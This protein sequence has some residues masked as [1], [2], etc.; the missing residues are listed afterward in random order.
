MKAGV[1][2]AL[3]A[4]TDEE[5]PDSGIFRLALL[6]VV[7]ELGGLGGGIHLRG[8]TTALRLVCSAG[9]P[10][11]LTRSWDVVSQ[12]EALAPAQAVLHGRDA[13]V[14]ASLSAPS[15]PPTEP[16]PGAGSASVPFFSGERAVGAITVLCEDEPTGEQW[17]FLRA[18]ASWTE[19]RT[20]KAAPTPSPPQEPLTGSG[21]RQAL[22]DV[23]IRAWEWDIHT[24]AL[25]WDAHATDVHDAIAQGYA[26]RIESWMKAVHP[27]DL[28]SA[29]AAAERMVREGVPYEAEYRQRRPD[30]SYGW[31]QA[32]GWVVRDDRGEP[33]RA[34]GVAW[35]TSESST[36]QNALGR[37]LRHM[38]D[39]FALVD[40]DWR[41]VF[42]NPGAA[43]TL[44]LAQSELLGR[45]LWELPALQNVPDLEPRCRKAVAA[46][47]PVG[48]DVW[49]A[50]EHCHH[51]RLVPGPDGLTLYLTDVTERRR[52]EAERAAAERAA[53][54]RSARI[55][56]LTTALARARTSRDV[57]ETVAQRVLPPFG[58]TGLTVITIEEDRA[59]IVGAVGYA[60]SFLDEITGR[61]VAPGDPVGDAVLTGAPLFIPSAEDYAQRYPGLGERPS[62][63]DKQGWAFLPLTV[64][65]RTFGVC[66]VSF[67]LPHQLTSDEQT[68]L[69]AISALVA[70][71]LDRARLY[72]AAHTRAQELQR[73]LLPKALPHMTECTAAAR[74]LSAGGTDVGGDWYD[75]IPLSSGRVALVVGDVMGHGLSEAATMG[76]LRTAVATLADLDLPPDELMSHLNDI[77]GGLGEDSYATCVYMVYDSTTGMCTAARAGHPPPAVV[78]PGGAVYFPDVPSNPPLGVAQPPFETLQFELS[79]ESLLVLYTDGLVESAQREVDQGMAE[80]KERL[81][82][83]DRADLEL[84]CDA[85]TASLLPGEPHTASDDAALL[86]VRVH[87]LA[88]E[89]M[90]SWQLPEDPR[91]AGEARVHIRNQLELWNLDDL[92]MTTELIGSELVGNVVRHAKG[93]VHLRLLHGTSL[94]CE[95]SDGSPTTPRIRRAA[96]TDEGGRGLQLVAALSQRW[97]TRFTTTGKCIWTEQTHG[98]SEGESSWESAESLFAIDL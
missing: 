83:A 7:A 3:L 68:L 87:A 96:E 60:Q 97:G 77:V 47:S 53:N 2:L 82:T 80:L 25:D 66:T 63:A 12:E 72:D 1:R 24:G 37:A 32:R 84:L 35:D 46:A 10:P 95:V 19:E 8:P 65:G 76:R 92:T 33:V 86:I 73:G 49:T 41:I 48:F 4:T 14:P 88:A 50:T 28:P 31:T 75:V 61:Q 55:A 22:R 23:P 67:E 29:L 42:A 57:V 45:P 30:G 43:R 26:P 16:W 62:R 34:V 20:G 94:I 89:R 54:E 56:E 27:D 79:D 81:R 15:D 98:G 59:E 74:F 52:R 78:E 91:A 90:A 71:A 70:H 9:L 93:P 11:S 5:T 85:L 39:G 64:S 6:H 69:T 36:A 51:L 18:V 58:A 40:D 44:G 17:E 21:L 13:W 38:S